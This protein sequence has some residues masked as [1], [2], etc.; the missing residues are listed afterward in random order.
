M[1]ITIKT[2]NTGLLVTLKDNER[3]E[4]HAFNLFEL[5]DFL[6]GELEHTLPDD[7]LDVPDDKVDVPGD[8]VEN[9]SK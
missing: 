7:K 3:K 1:K 2:I 9:S 5:I 8:D 4:K 6:D